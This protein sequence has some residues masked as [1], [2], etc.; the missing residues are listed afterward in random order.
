[1]LAPSIRGALGATRS[2]ILEFDG[3]DD[4]KTENTM[5]ATILL[6]AGGWIHACGVEFFRQSETL[7]WCRLASFF[8]SNGASSEVK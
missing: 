6:F 2:V 4:V 8:P 7:T 5:T 3:S 1:L